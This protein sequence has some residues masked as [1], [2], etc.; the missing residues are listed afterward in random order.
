LQFKRAAL[1]KQRQLLFFPGLEFNK[2]RTL[3]TLD[4]QRMF[5][6]QDVGEAKLWE[7][8]ALS[9]LWLAYNNWSK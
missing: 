2:G 5:E 4:R 3:K 7:F 9:V 1:A 8:S 6:L